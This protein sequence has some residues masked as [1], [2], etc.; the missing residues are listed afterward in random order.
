MKPNDTINVII[1]VP[2]IPPAE[3]RGNSNAHYM[4]KARKVSQLRTAGFLY[5]IQKCEE[6]SFLDYG[7]LY[8]RG[9]VKLTFAFYNN[10][11]ID[12]DNL[13]IGMKAFVDGL[14]DSNLLLE[15]TPDKV[16][17]G[18]H[19]FHKCAKG[20]EQTVITIEPRPRDIGKIEEVL[21]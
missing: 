14:V 3:L 15:D 10:R 12:L 2:W 21:R 6:L 8:S 11:A 13:A 19:T 17:Y 18:E 4:V 1:Q 20:D 9:T 16:I 7:R 5:G